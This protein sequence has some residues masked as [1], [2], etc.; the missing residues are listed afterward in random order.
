MT[1]FKFQINSKN[2]ITKISTNFEVWKLRFV[3]WGLFVICFLGIE[4]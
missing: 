3:I 1:K 2:L 4:I